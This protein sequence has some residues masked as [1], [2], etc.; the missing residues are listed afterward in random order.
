M[1]WEL[2]VSFVCR[3][4][5]SRQNLLL[6][7]V[8]K[9]P[10]PPRGSKWQHRWQPKQFS[11]LRKWTAT[12]QV[13]SWDE[14]SLYWAAPLFWELSDGSMCPCILKGLT[15]TSTPLWPN[16][17]E[18]GRDQANCEVSICKCL[19]DVIPALLPL[20]LAHSLSFPAAHLESK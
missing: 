4:S 11:S 13:A 5:H 7:G 14:S 2:R 16:F 8:L 15:I 6:M 10:W 20:S 12:S 17:S 18:F 3:M 9:K 1:V 19:I